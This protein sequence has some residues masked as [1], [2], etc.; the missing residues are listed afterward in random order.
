MVLPSV[1]SL[2]IVACFEAGIWLIPHIYARI[3]CYTM[4]LHR[5]PAA[6]LFVLGETLPLISHSYRSCAAA[7]TLLR[8]NG[9]PSSPSLSP[10]AS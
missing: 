2:E 8:S 6:Y 1:E 9:G 7:L 3:D 5:H 10:L 4:S